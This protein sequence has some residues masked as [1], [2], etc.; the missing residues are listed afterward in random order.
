[1]RIALTGATG[2]VGY[3]I[4]RHLAAQGHAVVTLGRRPLPG[5]AHHPWALGQSPN[6]RGVD[7]LIHVAFSHVPGRYRGGEGEDPAGFARANL[8]G[9]LRLWE[10]AEG[11]YSVFLSSRAV[12]GAYPPG[13]VLDEEMPPKPDTLYGE[14]KLAAEQALSH[15]VSLRITGVYGAHVP[16]RSH[17][18]SELFAARREGREIAP[19]IGTEVHVED[20]AQAIDLVLNQR[21][22]ARVLNVSDLVLDRHDLIRAFDQVAG[23]DG[24]L[25]AACDPGKVSVMRTNKLRALGWAPQGWLGLEKTLHALRNA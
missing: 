3:P 25:P 7:A 22:G 23:T 21:P 11:L 13:T 5:L 6:L 20:V 19:R 9:T 18:W 17:K 4:A 24:P 15:G 12:Y 14:V 1:M 8:D 2:L 16:G 10:A